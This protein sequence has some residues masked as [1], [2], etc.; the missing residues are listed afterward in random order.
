[1]G[2]LSLRL[3]AV[4]SCPRPST[5]PPQLPYSE[6]LLLQYGMPEYGGL[7]TIQ[8]SGP[9]IS[10]MLSTPPPSPSLL[11]PAASDVVSSYPPQTGLPIQSIPFPHSP[12]P[13]PSF[14]SIMNGPVM[15]SAMVVHESHTQVP[16][17]HEGQGEGHGVPKFHKL[18]FPTYD[19]KDEAF[20]V[21]CYSIPLDKWDMVLGVTFLRALGPILWD[22]NDLCMAFTL[23]DR[24]VSGGA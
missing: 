1:M 11:A 12:S 5:T 22:F 16:P 9:I 7:P 10:E 20:S 18:S 6:P 17:H 24:Q 2:E 4:E 21:D 19:D 8:A 14:S 13:V 23:G 3:T 15:S